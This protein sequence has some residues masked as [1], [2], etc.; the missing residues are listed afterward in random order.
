[1][2]ETGPS[3]LIYKELL[4]ISERKINISIEKNMGYDQKQAVHR[5]RNKITF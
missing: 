5:K 2:A 1:M 3:S 4:Q